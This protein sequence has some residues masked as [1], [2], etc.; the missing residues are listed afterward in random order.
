MCNDVVIHGGTN[1]VNKDTEDFIV[2]ELDIDDN[3]IKPSTA[4][5]KIPHHYD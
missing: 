1:D 3:G 4:V 2:G 5:S